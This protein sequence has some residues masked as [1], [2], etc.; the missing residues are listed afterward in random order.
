MTV[1][2]GSAGP[3]SSAPAHSM[4]PWP[5]CSVPCLP[6][7][8]WAPGTNIVHPSD[9]KPEWQYIATRRVWGSGSDLDKQHKQTI[10]KQPGLAPAHKLGTGQFQGIFC[11]VVH[12]LKMKMVLYY[13][14][15]FFCI[16]QVIYYSVET[17][18]TMFNFATLTIHTYIMHNIERNIH[19]GNHICQ[20]RSGWNQR[21]NGINAQYK[22]MLLRSTLKGNT[23]D[24]KCSNGDPQGQ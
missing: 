18:L 19:E 17:V 1:A 10:N 4:G 6:C 8:C 14:I 13:T 3:R 24:W 12:F 2:A 5:G 9:L 15:N 22:T 11:H 7:Q 20:W 16:I 21:K 23:G